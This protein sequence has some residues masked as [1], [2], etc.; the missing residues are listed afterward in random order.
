MLLIT[1]Q[2]KDQS[3]QSLNQALLQLPMPHTSPLQKQM[4]F[5][6]VVQVTRQHTTSSFLFPAELSTTF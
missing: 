2:Q 5:L 6:L 3:P 1:Y 4:T